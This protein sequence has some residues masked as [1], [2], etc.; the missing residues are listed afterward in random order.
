M[1]QQNPLIVTLAR[2][3]ERTSPGDRYCWVLLSSLHYPQRA[4]GLISLLSCYL[5]PT[6][7]CIFVCICIG[8]LPYLFIIRYCTKILAFTVML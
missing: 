6:T 2:G 8:L 1:K 5:I 4:F 7:I 3:S